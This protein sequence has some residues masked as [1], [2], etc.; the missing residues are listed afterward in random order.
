MAKRGLKRRASL[1][2]LSSGGSS[3]TAQPSPFQFTGV[4]CGPHHTVGLTINGSVYAWGRNRHGQLGVGDRKSHNAP[5]IVRGGLVGKRVIELG[6]GW[7]SSY[8]LTEDHA[9]Y[10][11]GR[12]GCFQV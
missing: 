12:A 10:T 7:A 9:L 3:A 4:C 1:S 11:W 8:A 2:S 5:M 6:T